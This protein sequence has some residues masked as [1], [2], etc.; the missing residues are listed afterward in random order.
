MPVLVF[1]TC[2]ATCSKGV[3]V[4]AETEEI[5]GLPDA[6]QASSSLSIAG[7]NLENN[8]LLDPVRNYLLSLFDALQSGL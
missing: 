8:D 5:G 7:T 4:K 6:S 2:S 1:D 3:V